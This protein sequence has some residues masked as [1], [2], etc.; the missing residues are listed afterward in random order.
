MS[1]F[2]PLLGVMFREYYS[3]RRFLGIGNSKSKGKIIGISIAILYALVA[4]FASFYFMFN[5]LAVILHQMNMLRLLIGFIFT[6]ATGFTVLYVLFRADSFLFHFRD[7]ELIA[8]LPVKPIELVLVKVILMMTGLYLMV[9]LMTSPILIVYFIHTGFHFWKLLIYLIGV[10]FVPLLPTILFS[11][12]A[13]LLHRVSKSF[14]NNKLASIILLMIFT[15]ALI[16]LSTALSLS[17]DGFLIGQTNVIEWINAHY[18]VSEWFIQAVDQADFLKLGGVMLLSG[19]PFTLFVLAL[20]KPVV[21]LNQAAANAKQQAYVKPVYESRSVFRSLVRK[22]AMKFFSVPMYA[23]NS[24]IGIVMLLLAAVAA[25]IFKQDLLVFMELPDMLSGIGELVVI[26]F[27]SFC[28]AMVYTPA[29]SLSLEGKAFW[30]VKSLPLEPKKIMRA[31]VAFNLLLQVPAALIGSIMMAIAFDVDWIPAI[32]ILFFITAFAFLVSSAFALINLF[33]PKFDWI[34][35]IE[36]VKQSLAAIVAIFGSFGV[37]ALAIF[38]ILQLSSAIPMPAA[39][40]I[41]AV[42]FLFLGLL[43][44]RL[45]ARFA[46]NLFMK[47][48]A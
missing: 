14:K 47:M 34:N 39:I 46:E 35:E 12:A 27:A 2:K 24:G 10:L 38:L 29:V 9:F 26:G 1:A 28:V 48:K 18:P 21:K 3:P 16:V 5:E 17:G 8:P 7:Y 4:M 22:E 6:Y 33:L 23:M 42:F 37:I 13:L 11:F 20:P 41:C 32:A 36:V 45:V 43:F 25:L 19:I 40:F 30:I 44:D 31:K 15:I